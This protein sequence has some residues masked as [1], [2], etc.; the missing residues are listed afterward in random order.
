VIG[1]TVFY[2][3]MPPFPGGAA[4]RGDAVVTALSATLRPL[5]YVIRVVTAAGEPRRADGVEI[6]VLPASDVENAAK[7]AQR[8][9]GELRLGWQVGRRLTRGRPAAAYISSPA[10]L[11]ALVA[12]L[13]C[14]LCRVPY[15]LEV[16]DVYP[17][18]YMHAGLLSASSLAY[19]LLLA[20]SK[21]MYTGARRIIVVTQGLRA[22]VAP[23]AASVPIDCIYNGYPES[24]QRL[25]PPKHERFTVCFHGVLGFFQDIE[26][27]I[28]L[29]ARLAAHDI[30]MVVIGYGRKE[31]LLRG[32]LPGNLRFLGRLAFERTVAEVARCHVGLCL[33]L[34]DE[35]S[36][37]AFPIKVWEYLGL[38]MPSIV[39]PPCEAGQFVEQHRCGFQLPAGDIEALLRT[40]LDLRA[41]PQRIAAI[42]RNCDAVSPQY[43]REQTGKQ[44]AQLVVQT[45]HH[46]GSARKTHRG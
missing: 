3:H 12:T 31:S 24:L 16:R 22:S 32:E 19:R 13:W 23:L 10:F 1:F 46:D 41:D 11:A 21:Y 44:V 45:L 25:R 5:G 20:A 39:T 17:Q 34:Q 30:D 6:D 26:T 27:L 43:S 18:V 38:G 28:V 2:Q 15:V 14:R 8:V 36:R 37:D 40:I 29:A 42:A 35:I 33:R 4:L 7:L 9:G